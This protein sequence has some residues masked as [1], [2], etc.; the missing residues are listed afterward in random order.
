MTDSNI[1][2]ADNLGWDETPAIDTQGGIVRTTVSISA[3]GKPLGL[4]CYLKFEDVVEFS[5]PVA[6]DIA[7][8]RRVGLAEDLVRQ[9]AEELKASVEKLRTEFA[10]TPKGAVSIHAAA[11]ATPAASRINTPAPAGTGAPAVVAVAN[12]ATQAQGDWRSVPSRFGDGQIRFI[13]SQA[14][15]SDQLKFDVSN[16][17]T[18]QGIDASIFDIWDERTGPRGAE[19]GNPIGSVFN[20]KVKKDC[21]SAVPEDFHRNAAGRGKFR[22]DGSIEPYWSKDFESYLKFG[23]REK[24]APAGF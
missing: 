7:H 5:S 6:D 20:I 15:S 22:A 24:L 2:E 13:S 9:L 1:N 16:W 23:G 14:Y 4:D 18:G 12:G 19:A 17:I 10:N 11:P 8:Y 3:S 21:Q